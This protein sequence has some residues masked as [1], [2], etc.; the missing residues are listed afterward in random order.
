MYIV[1]RSYKQ[2]NLLSELS[3]LYLWGN[4]GQQARQNKNKRRISAR[5]DGVSEAPR[6]GRQSAASAELG[7]WPWRKGLGQGSDGRD[8]AATRNL[9]VIILLIGMHREGHGDSVHHIS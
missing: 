6:G 4:T 2:N 8:Q 5:D 9:L 1:G 3:V 7:I